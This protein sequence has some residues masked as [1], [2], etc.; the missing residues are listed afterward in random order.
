MTILNFL[1]P[2]KCLECGLSAQAGKTGRYLCES[3]LKKVPSA[4]W[5]NREIYS[6]WRYQGVI[7][8][9]VI[10]LKYKYATEIIQELADLSVRKLTTTF[11]SLSATLVPIPLHWHRRNLRGFNQSTEI[12]KVVAQKMGWKFVPD[13]L[14]RKKSTVPQVEL[15]G[16]ARRTNLKNAF[17]LNSKYQRLDTN[18]IIFDDVLTT[19]STLMEAAKI[20][21]KSGVAKVWGLTLAR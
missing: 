10:A 20:L 14:F 8:K 3:C 2:K 1:F 21:K 11:S 5:T 17:S 13:L 9:A 16:K 12:G 6:L 19:G 4:G 18:Y 7:R 15:K